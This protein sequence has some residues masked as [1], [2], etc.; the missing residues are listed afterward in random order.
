LGDDAPPELKKARKIPFF[1]ASLTK[2]I[3]KIVCGGMHTVALSTFGKVYS[4]GCNDE[5]ALGRD[6]QENVPLEVHSSLA[7]PMTDIAAGD[8]HSLAYST[9]LNCVYMWGL[10]R[11]RFAYHSLELING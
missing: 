4:W 3:T 9:S 1:D 11:V 8:S 2:H 7:F 5:G 6:G 10:Y